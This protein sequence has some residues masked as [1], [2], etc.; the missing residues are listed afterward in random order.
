ME[1]M[2]LATCFLFT[3]HLKE[4]GCLSLKLDQQGQIEAPL[5]HRSFAEIQAL[6]VGS[7]TYL[8]TSGQRFSLHKLELPWLAERKARAAIPFAL[9]DKLAQNFDTLHFAFDR[10]HY[11]NGHYLIVVSDRTYLQ[12]LMATLDEQRINF[13]L[14]TL[15]WFALM[16]DEIVVMA[17]S[18]LAN[19]EFFQGALSP[20]LAPF[21]LAK[22]SGE[23][24][25]Y[26][27]TDSNKELLNNSSL[28]EQLSEISEPSYQWI[29]QRLLTTRPINL[30]QGELQHGNSNTIIKRLYQAAVAM[31][32]LWLLSIIIINGV[33]LYFIDR[34]IAA[35]DSKIAVIYREFFP[36][37]QQVISPKFRIAQLIRTNQGTN[38]LTFWILLNKL[39]KN[40]KDSSVTIDQLRFQNQTLTLNLTSKDFETLEDLQTKLQKSNINVK[41]TQASSKDGKVVGTLELYL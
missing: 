39:A 5:S 23:R 40:Y 9:E 7:R 32:L 14:L 1:D 16:P 6:Q 25:I 12:D 35:V 20:D 26:S 18:L 37:A 30:C 11:Q 21:Y 28:L 22:W 19:D 31:S 17:N 8:V 27:F 15:D 38:D 41:Q 13:D 10:N 4:D 36:E 2:N 29:A 34:D 3:E 24:T 33:K